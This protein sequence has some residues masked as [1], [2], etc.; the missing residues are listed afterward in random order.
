V[1]RAGPGQLRLEGGLQ[2]ARQ[3]GDAVPAALAVAHQ[4]LGALRFEVEDA[5]AQA[6]HEAQP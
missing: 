2:R 5:Q 1:E 6:L 4:D 3:H